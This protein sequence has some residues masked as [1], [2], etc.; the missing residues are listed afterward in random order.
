MAK[1]FKATGMIAAMA[2]GALPF[3]AQ[4]QDAPQ[5][6]AAPAAPQAPAQPAPPQSVEMSAAQLFQYADAAR[7]RGDYP[8]A[9]AAY[10]A[11][12]ADPDLDLRTEARFRLAMMYMDQMH[13]PRDA[14]VLLRRILDDKPDVARVR[15]ELARVQVALGN[16]GDAAR[17][18]RAA[19]AAGLPPEVENQV[20]F[21]ANALSAQKRFGGGFEIAA[22]PSSNVNRATKS[23]TLGTIIG[24]FVLSDDA[25][26]QSGI[27][28]SVKGQ[29]YYRLPAG[30]TTDVLLRASA[31]GDL[32]RK[33]EFDDI[34][35]SLQAGPQW[36]WGRDRLA[37]SAAT[38]WRWY[39]LEYYSFSYGLTGNWQ[40]PLSPRTQLRIDG[41]VLEENNVR[42]DLED[43]E[44]YTLALGIDHSFSPRFGGG[45][46]LSGNRDQASDP[47]YSTTSGGVNA[48]L[49]RELGRTTAVANVSYRHL[50]ADERLF[51]YPERR[52]DD[53]ASVSL[54]GT[55]RALTFHTFAPLLRVGYERNWSTVEIYSFDRFYSEIGIVAAF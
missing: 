9:E 30:K 39:G 4:A 26:A 2:A 33:S 19:E 54:S 46:Q 52:K 25:K 27:G 51:L 44:N 35:G 36:Q 45:F 38:T 17:E 20:R 34:S 29:T 28:L 21:F 41:S 5:E 47:G 8:T 32:Y 1:L 18:L 14:A 15:V 16:L 40:H 48:Y 53:Y 43:G 50:E 31:S 49:Y 6:A 12:A 11:L 22:A 3:A 10:Q 55:F 24:D 37:L 42:N 7:D 13:K 23:D